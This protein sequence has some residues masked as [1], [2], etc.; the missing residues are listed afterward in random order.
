MSGR[1]KLFVTML[2]GYLGGPM[3]MRRMRERKRTYGAEKREFIVV[4]EGGISNRALEG[5]MRILKI[6]SSNPVRSVIGGGIKKKLA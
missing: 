2:K 5:R 1:G 4:V 3:G 6:R